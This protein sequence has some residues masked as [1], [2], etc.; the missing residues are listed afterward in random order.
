MNAGT[1][2]LIIVGVIAGIAALG[3]GAYLLIFRAFFKTF[4]KTVDKFHIDD[5]FDF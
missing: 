5:D 4:N 3:I 2:I 1:I